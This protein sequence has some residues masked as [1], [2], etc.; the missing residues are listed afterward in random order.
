MYVGTIEGLGQEI[1]VARAVQLNHQAGQWLGWQAQRDRIAGFLGLTPAADA[2]AFAEA[3]A[4]WQRSQGLTA[5]GIIGPCAWS[6]MQ[7]ELGLGPPLPC[8]TRVTFRNTG[9]SDPD[10]CCANCPI[11]L[12]VGIE[13]GAGPTA[14]NGME[15]QFTIS[16]HRR[17][18]EYDL[19]RTRRSSLWERRAGVWTRLEFD[20]MGTRDDHHDDDECL[21][22]R[23][24]RIFAEDRPGWRTVLPAPDGTVFPTRRG[25]VTQADATDVVRRHNFAEWAIVRSRTEGIPWTRISLPV[26]WHSILWLTRNAANQWVLDQARSRIARGALT[27]AVINAAPA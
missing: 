20:P 1:N 25:S 22:P 15:L 23:G 12:G 3:V 6:R 8:V 27:A 26:F 24:N 11:N 21:I 2:R 14:S 16:G 4:R 13:R 19:T 10:N 17:G 9:T 5:D 18:L 7:T